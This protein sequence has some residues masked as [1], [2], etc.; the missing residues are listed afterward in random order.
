M[1]Y[2]MKG[3][4]MTETGLFGVKS[5]RNNIYSLLEVFQVLLLY[6]CLMIRNPYNFSKSSLN[7]FFACKKDVFYRF[8]SNPDIDWRKLVYHLNLQLW[9]KIR[10]R[11]DH[12]DCTTCLIVDDT[13]YPK[14]G[15]R[16]ENIGRVHSHA[17]I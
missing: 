8:M 3:L 13:D 12:K 4:K 7:H 6:P 5:K 9:S 2:L 10:V 15:R 11:S 1:T 16:I 17:H 14:T